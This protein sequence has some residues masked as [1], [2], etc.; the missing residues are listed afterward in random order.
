MPHIHRFIK[1]LLLATLPPIMLLGGFYIWKDPFKVLRE[2]DDYYPVGKLRPGMNKGMVVIRNFDRNFGTEHYDSFIFGSSLSKYYRIKEWTQYLPEGSKAIHLDSS[3]E[4]LHSMKLKIAYVLKK[5]A[6]IKNALIVLPP[7]IFSHKDIE[8]PPYIDYWKIDPERTRLQYHWHFISNFFNRE[9]LKEYI[10]SSLIS[11]PLTTT[12]PMPLDTATIRIDMLTNEEYHPLADRHLDTDPVSYLRKKRLL[13]ILGNKP[14]EME[15]HATATGLQD[16]K[17]IAALLDSAGTDYRV[18]IGP[19][20]DNRYTNHYD[21]DLLRRTFGKDRVFDYSLSLAGTGDSL[22]KFY[23]T[24]H[25]RSIV[26]S[27]IMRRTYRGLKK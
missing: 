19:R 20:L 11:E 22:D 18:V 10:A 4:S 24:T 5:G 7:D 15:S 16:A 23:D 8:A 17:E 6:H 26:A 21:L 2:Y 25:Y 14:E 27:E 12:A 1:K 9:F 13:A 3:L